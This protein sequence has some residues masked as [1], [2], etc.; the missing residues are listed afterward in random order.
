M[1]QLIA[2]VEE[3]VEGGEGR[4]GGECEGKRG[5]GGREGKGGGKGR[6]RG[7]EGLLQVLVN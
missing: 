2:V 7:K 6:E 1:P 5:E 3:E 4:D